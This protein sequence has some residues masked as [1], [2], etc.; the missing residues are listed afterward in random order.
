MNKIKEIIKRIYLKQYYD[1]DSFT[2]YLKKF[3]IIIGKGT[4]FFDP[5]NTKID[6]TR[7]YLLEI[8]D[9]CKITSGVTILTH[10]YSRS[11]LR[12]KYG[13]IIGEAKKVKIGDNVF[14]GMN[15][16]I[17]MGSEIGNNVIIGANS[18]VTGKF[19]DN[20]VIAG[21]PA[22]IVMSL[23]EYYNRRKKK[24]IYEAK[25]Y[26]KL[27]YKNTGKIPDIKLFEGFFPIFMERDIKK[28]NKI[29]F[30]LNLSG[31]D[32][33]DIKDK[34]INSKPIYNSYNEFLNSID[35]ND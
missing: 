4:K 29:G 19:P 10:D 24:Y 35:F 2:K 15:S 6:I 30:K 26:A 23:E 5:K 27:I 14:I 17:L 11:V 18:L 32:S 31:D 3:G 33:E 1:S 20:V 34:F 12:Y 13:E 16:T 8:G 28:V 25:E 22:K 21:N 9:Y 7:P